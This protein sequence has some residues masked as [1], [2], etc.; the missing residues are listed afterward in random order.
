MSIDRLSNLELLGLP[1]CM[2]LSES[3]KCI[4][5]NIRACRGEECAFKRSVSEY[6]SLQINTFQRLGNLGSLEQ[7]R[8]ADKYYNGRK[9][10]NMR[11]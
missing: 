11:Y 9:P 3:G 5:L 6:K 7:S 2:G 4:W 10:W 1:D 8:I